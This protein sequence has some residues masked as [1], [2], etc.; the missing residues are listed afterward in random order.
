MKFLLSLVSCSVVGVSSVSS[1]T[2]SCADPINLPKDLSSYNVV[3]IPKNATDYNNLY[4][5][6]DSFAHWNYF[7]TDDLI[8][9]IYSDSTGKN[10]VNS[11][12]IQTVS[13]NNKLYIQ[14][15]SSPEALTAE[16][17]TSII[18]VNFNQKKW[19][20]DIDFSN[21]QK[22]KSLNSLDVLKTYLKSNILRSLHNCISDISMADFTINYDSKK[23]LQNKKGDY[24][25][26]ISSKT[27]SKYLKG[28]LELDINVKNSKN[29]ETL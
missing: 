1:A 19:I 23:P 15:S 10:E 22:L 5:I 21:C 20:D 17:N 27:A 9:H 6:V 26:E 25:V 28:G 18:P 7:Y 16:N 29:K 8:S 13:D 11:S 24:K 4:S 14:I 2:I 3:N 12:Y